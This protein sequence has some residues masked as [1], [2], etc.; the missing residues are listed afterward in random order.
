MVLTALNS[1]V[2]QGDLPE[3]ALLG[4]RPDNAAAGGIVENGFLKNGKVVQSGMV[5]DTETGR[6]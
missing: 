2:G 6:Y 3:I 4:G 1:E 5:Y